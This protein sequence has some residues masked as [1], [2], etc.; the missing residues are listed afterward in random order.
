MS[1][2]T[3]EKPLLW[4]APRKGWLMNCYSQWT[5]F[6]KNMNRII[7]LSNFLQFHS[8]QFFE[9]KKHFKFKS[10]S[11]KIYIITD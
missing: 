1:N 3:T 7:C 11:R 5:Y 4:N 2:F 9:L 8:S 10:I 6:S